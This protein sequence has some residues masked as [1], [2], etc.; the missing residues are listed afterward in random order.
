M[1]AR[2]LLGRP[3]EPFVSEDPPCTI[4]LQVPKFGTIAPMLQRLA[5]HSQ[6]AVALLRGRD[7]E[8]E[9]LEDIHVELV[10]CCLTEGMDTDETFEL[11]VALG[12]NLG[13]S[14]DPLIKR[15]YELCGLKSSDLSE[16]E[17][18]EMTNKMQDTL[19]DKGITD[20]DFLDPTSGRA[21]S[22]G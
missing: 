11:L 8:L 21:A 15:C 19:L 4:P 17:L 14:V 1:P 7:V 12:V 20:Q 3:V 5:S 13:D 6:K 2:D 9:A 22:T 18:K 10:R 16:D